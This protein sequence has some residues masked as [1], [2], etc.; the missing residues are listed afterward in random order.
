[1]RSLT[2][3]IFDRIKE[4]VTDYRGDMNPT[5]IHCCVITAAIYHLLTCCDEGEE[6]IPA[7]H[8]IVDEAFGRALRYWRARTD[9][10]WAA[11]GARPH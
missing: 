2:Q 9:A 10:E 1:M 6:D 7:V 5:D 8:W 3:Y 11:A 4:E